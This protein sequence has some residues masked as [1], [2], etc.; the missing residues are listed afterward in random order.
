MGLRSLSGLW[1]N[2]DDI[3]HEEKSAQD[4][5]GLSANTKFYFPPSNVVPGY[6]SAKKKDSAQV[7][8]VKLVDHH[9]K[10][11]FSSFLIT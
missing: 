8:L 1:V 11:L 6:D 5:R 4:A 2:V 7:E 9:Y 3:Y 10:L